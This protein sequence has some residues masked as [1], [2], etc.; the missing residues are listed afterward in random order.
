MHGFLIFLAIA[1]AVGLFIWW[2]TVDSKKP[3]KE[4]KRGDW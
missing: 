4:R 2:V 3:P 1:W